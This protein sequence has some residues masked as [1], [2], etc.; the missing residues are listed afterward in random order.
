MSKPWVPKF[1]QSRWTVLC[2]N[3]EKTNDHAISC[4][5]CYSRS[6]GKGWRLFF[7][8]EGCGRSIPECKKSTYDGLCLDCH[9]WEN[10]DRK[11]KLREDFQVAFVVHEE[12][13]DNPVIFEGFAD[14]YYAAQVIAQEG[15]HAAIWLD[16]Q[17]EGQDWY[18]DCIFELGDNDA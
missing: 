3:A 17:H 11:L 4:P 13:A 18:E 16:I 9:R 14:A 8:C 6:G 5:K 1:Q 10:G 12:G 15:G 7:E 2:V